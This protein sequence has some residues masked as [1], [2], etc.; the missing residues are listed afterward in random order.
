M[1]AEKVF[2][3]LEE[4][5]LVEKLRN[6]SN[7]LFIGEK[8]TLS[9]LENV[10]NSNHSYGFWLPNNP[11]KFI[12]REQLLGCKA[13]VVASVKN[14][15]VM[16]KKVEEYLN[17]LEID[18]PVLRLFADVF[19][20]LMSGQKLLSSSDCQIIF[21]KLSYAVITTP[22]S[23]STFLCEALKSTNIA[24]YPVEH[25]RQPSAILAVH[26]HFDYLRYLKIMM[27][28]K[29]TENGV[30]GT[31]FISHFLEVLE[32]KTSLNFEKIVNTYI[33]KF[34]YLVRRDKVAQAVSVVMAKKTNVWHIFNQETEQEYQA[35]LNDLD[36]E[37]NDLEEVRKYYENIL[38]QEAYLEN[39]FQV[40]NI[41]PLIVEYE[42]LLADPD[43]EIQK[44]LRYLGVFAGE[45]QIN[46]QSYARKLR[47][48]LSDKIIHKYLEKYG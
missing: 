9:Y 26:C 14:E 45:Q 27:T 43:G 28:H 37:E 42:Q 23:G 32:T 6:Q 36:V 12:N 39:L 20:N 44:I 4:T 3:N 10:L 19:V 38:E 22:R 7:L 35:R 24:G 17:S 21:P 15:N 2:H 11:G 5:N 25:L 30:F 18:I 31:K 13:V 41:S 46:I 40:Y 8:E 33:S 29:V 47:S 1:Q 34:V 16:L 48:G